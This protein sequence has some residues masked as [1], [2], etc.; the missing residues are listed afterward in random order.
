MKRNI[1]TEVTQE[2]KECNVSKCNT[3][4][5]PSITSSLKSH[6]QTL[7]SEINFLRSK[8]QEKNALVKSLVTSHML[9][10]LGYMKTFMFHIKHLK[11]IHL[12]AHENM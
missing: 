11:Q 12:L 4:T 2:I 6:I 7:E 5:T 3:S 8:L 1:L 9:T 10:F